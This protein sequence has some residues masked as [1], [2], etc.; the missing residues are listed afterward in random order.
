MDYVLEALKRIAAGESLEIPADEQEA[1]MAEVERLSAGTV[2]L[3]GGCRSWYVDPRSNRLTTL[4]PD[5]S[6]T[7]R[8]VNSTFDAQPYR[9]ETAEANA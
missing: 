5:F 4:W 3:S 6:F 1:Y 8:E 2:W 7:F 9:L